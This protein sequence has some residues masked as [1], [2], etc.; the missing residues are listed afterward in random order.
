MIEREVLKER[1]VVKESYRSF[2]RGCRGD[3]VCMG[4]TGLGN[5]VTFIVVDVAIVAILVE[6][7]MKRDIRSVKAIEEVVIICVIII[8]KDGRIPRGRAGH[9]FL[10]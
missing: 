3:E 4:Y 10:W 6:V 1:N 8:V 5:Y 7:G 2:I 9:D